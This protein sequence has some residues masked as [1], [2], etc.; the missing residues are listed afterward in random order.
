MTTTTTTA[1]SSSPSPHTIASAVVS[2]LPT[3]SKP[4]GT[5]PTTTPSSTIPRS[6]RLNCPANN[7][8]GL[9]CFKNTQCVPVALLCSY[10]AT[11]VNGTTTAMNHP[12]MDTTGPATAQ[13]PI[14]CQEQLCIANNFLPLP[15]PGTGKMNRNSSANCL[16]GSY[17]SLYGSS[18]TASTGGGMRYTQSCIASNSVPEQPSTV[19]KEWEYLAQNSCLLKTCGP[20]MD[21]EP[22]FICRKSKYAAPPA[23]YGLCMNPNSTADPGGDDSTADNDSSKDHLLIGLLVG[24]CSLVVGTGV[25]AA[26]WHFRKTRMRQLALLNSEEDDRIL[27]EKTSFMAT[28]RSCCCGIRSRARGTHGLGGTRDMRV[29][30]V[31]ESD[32]HESSLMADHRTNLIFARRWRWGAGVQH[33]EAGG[34]AGMTAGGV[35][36]IPEMEPP[37]LYHQGHDLPS[38]RDRNTILLTPVPDLSST[39]VVDPP[40]QEELAT[41]PTPK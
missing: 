9:T 17:F 12:C 35:A 32:G 27:R 34:R 21:C 28:I 24:L 15:A 22:P 26:F 16:K 1:I 11:A 36:I 10:T 33:S 2:A 13:D 3:T 19:C 37:P 14:T 5:Q 38:Y 29:V 30:S 31:A 39:T 25:G 18:G 23:L 41:S 40:E 8:F 20:N 7:A 4:L 6:C